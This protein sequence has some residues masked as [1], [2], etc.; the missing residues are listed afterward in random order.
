MTFRFIHTADWQLGRAFGMFEPGLAGQLE[1]ARFDAIDRIASVA[2]AT[3]AEHVLVAGDVFDTPDLAPRAIRQA[4]ERMRGYPQLTWVL[5]AGNHDPAR[6]GGIWDRVRSL[7]VPDNVTPLLEAG[8]HSLTNGVVV[9][10]APLS[11]R[12]VVVDPTAA[13]DQW[14]TPAGVTRLGLAHG[15]VT[16]F[17]SQASSVSIDPRRAQLARLDY[18]AL[19]DWH[20]VQCIDPKTWYSGT[21]EPDRFPK[22]KPGFVLAV[23]LPGPGATPVVTPHPT[24][25]FTW[26]GHQARLS[27]IAEIEPIE[28]AL[29]NS[30]APPNRILAKVVF[31]GTLP[32]SHH[33]KLAAWRDQLEGRFHFF[34]VD[35][36][37][38]GISMGVADVSVLGDDTALITAASRLRDRASAGDVHAAK[39]LASLFDLTRR[40]REGAA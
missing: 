37:A 24:A 5:L 3:G 27:E 30:G 4:L 23:T 31:T 12:A 18:L 13:M 22:N 6:P 38:L 40:A 16:D 11:N 35:V 36:D 33:A 25:H 10:A 7:G 15:S 39:A 28:R 32:A 19:G 26:V 17:G 1:A 14:A 20:G 9:L 2:I 8:V 21:P 34:D 29:L